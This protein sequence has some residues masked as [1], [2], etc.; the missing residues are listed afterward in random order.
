MCH[1]HLTHSSSV[2]TE[3]ALAVPVCG[4][5]N[6]Q[7]A[8]SPLSLSWTSFCVTATRGTQ[9][10]GSTCSTTSSHGSTAA[11]SNATSHNHSG[12]LAL[13]VL[14][15]LLL[16]LLMLTAAAVQ[17]QAV[18]ASRAHGQHTMQPTRC[19]CNTN[20]I[21]S[22]RSKLLPCAPGRQQHACSALVLCRVLGLLLQL[23]HCHH[24]QQQQWGVMW[25]L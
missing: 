11:G 12:Q 17:A 10:R 7:M 4:V 2:N 8:C 6:T 21:S 9:G 3:A 5:P 23:Y 14:L 24:Q 1:R 20:I 13:L 25:R 15:S 18:C 19:N 16:A 22:S